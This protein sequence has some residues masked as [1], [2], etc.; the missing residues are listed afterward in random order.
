VRVLCWDYTQH[1][2]K[3]LLIHSKAAQ[4]KPRPL[5]GTTVPDL[6]KLQ[7]WQ[8]RSGKHHDPA[9]LPPNSYTV[10][11]P[12]TSLDLFSSFNTDRR[13]AVSIMTRPLYP[14][15]GR[16]LCFPLDRRLGR[17]QSSSRRSVSLRYVQPV[18]YSSRCM[19]YLANSMHQTFRLSMTIESEV[20]GLTLP[21]VQNSKC[22]KTHR[23]GNWICFCPQVRGADT[24]SVGSLRK[25]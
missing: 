14:P 8:E 19:S 11:Q 23:Y 24:Y 5:C 17:P 18:A 3:C 22:K 4:Y 20:L 15:N 2:C 21:I 25:S 7:H 6:L 9:A 10:K 12:N 13:G 1:C 16:E